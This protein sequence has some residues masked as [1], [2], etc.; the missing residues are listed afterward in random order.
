MGLKNASP[1]QADAQRYAR[2]LDWGTRLGV[3]L[4]LCSFSAYL[5]GLLPPHVPLERLPSLWNQPVATY[6]ELTQTPKDWG[7]LALIGHGDLSNM[8]GIA[9]LA[10]CS[11]PPLLALIPLFL[12]QGDRAYAVICALEVT[13]LLLAASGVLTAGH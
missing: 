1:T 2:L 9:L 7:W 5:F 10:S 6:L 8:L 3:V 4:L 13:V 12:K 11:V